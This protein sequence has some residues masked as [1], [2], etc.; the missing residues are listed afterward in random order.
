MPAKQQENQPIADVSPLA[1]SSDRRAMGAS[2]DASGSGASAQDHEQTRVENACH[3]LRQPLQSLVMLHALLARSVTGPE[4]LM[5]L[6]RISGAVDAMTAVVASLSEAQ[7]GALP[8]TTA[9][10]APAEAC[11]VPHLP[12]STLQQSALASEGATVFVVDDD[13]ACRGAIV[14]VLEAEG[15]VVVPFESCEAFLAH[16]AGG[17]ECCVLVDAYLPGMSGLALLQKLQSSGS[18]PPAIM[19]TGNSDVPMAVQAMK[20]GAVDFVEKPISRFELLESINRAVVHAR[21]EQQLVSW[22]H[23]AATQVA[24]LTS[25]QREIMDMVLAGQPSKNI[26]AD[27]GISQRTV[28]NHRASIM[29]RTGAKSLPALARLAVAAKSDKNLGER[30]TP[31]LPQTENGVGRFRGSLRRDSDAFLG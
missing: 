23:D 9:P 6:A 4:P 18:G 16:G 14:S 22:R 15:F 30:G 24:G 29:K 11:A 7:A 26:A 17:I 3:Q 2:A 10:P 13:A 21:D 28:E 8:A 5:L 31:A 19:I 12:S 25:R 27:L 20:A 1:P